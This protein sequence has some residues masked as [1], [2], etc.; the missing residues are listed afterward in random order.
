MADW[1]HF[2]LVR[3][4]FLGHNYHGWQKQPNHPSIHGTIDSTLEKILKGAPFKTIGCSRTDAKVS[5][6]DYV[7]ELFTQ[8]EIIP[9]Q[10]LHRLNKNLPP[11]IKATTISPTHSE[12]NII[13]GAK[14]KEYHYYFSF[15]E[16]SHPFSSPHAQHF[17]QN[18]NLGLMTKAAG[19]F[20]GSHFFGWYTQ[21]P[22]ENTL[23]ERE[24]LSAQIVHN[25][26]LSGN[27]FPENSFVFVVKAEGFL[28]YQVRMM[29]GALLEVGSG[30]WD[31]ETLKASLTAGQ[32][33]KIIHVAPAIGLVLHR[34][35]LMPH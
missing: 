2:H 6:A 33:N 34:V 32:F 22:S 23:L 27:F 30:V 24:I 8:T 1:T 25:H 26:F 20:E 4:Q 16:K 35:E 12:F 19:E 18:L 31:T 5:A 7:F 21:K 10:L 13:Q 14:A 9:D 17:S 28:R 3:I 29:M 11:D 15:G